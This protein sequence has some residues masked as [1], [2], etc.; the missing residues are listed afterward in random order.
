MC[1]SMANMLC[2]NGIYVRTCIAVFDSM[3][4]FDY[5]YKTNRNVLEIN[6]SITSIDTA[7][8]VPM[9]ITKKNVKMP[10]T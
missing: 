6:P 10:F 5:E 9:H 7:M 8:R 3:I 1:N 4:T 2:C